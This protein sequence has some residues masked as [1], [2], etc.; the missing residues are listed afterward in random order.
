[1]LI[2][3][4]SGSTKSNWMNVVEDEKFH[5]FKTGLEPIF[6]APSVKIVYPLDARAL[7][8][9]NGIQLERINNKNCLV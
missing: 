5:A 1:M 4:E 8:T 6:L 3:D 9:Y 7:A 2:V